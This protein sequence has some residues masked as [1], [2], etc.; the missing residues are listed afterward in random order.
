MGSNMRWPFALKEPLCRHHLEGTPPSL[1]IYSGFV[2]MVAM[3][4][5]ATDLTDEGGLILS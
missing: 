2:K 1:I 4:S 5:V 3:R